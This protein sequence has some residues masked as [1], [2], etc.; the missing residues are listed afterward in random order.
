MQTN[1]EQL[2]R[3]WA[4]WAPLWEHLEDQ[5][6]GTATAAQ[7][8]GLVQEPVLVLGAGQGLVVD[9]YRRLGLRAFGLD[10]NPA[11]VQAGRLRRGLCLVQAD[12][13][14]LPFLAQSFGTVIFSSGVV[15]YGA[16]RDD[17]G[18]MLG[19]ARRVL[20]PGGRIA[21]AFYQVEPE[22]LAIYRKLGVVAGGA[23]HPERMFE[24]DD[25]VREAPARAVPKIAAWSGRSKASSFLFFARL[26]LRLPRA[27]E[28]ERRR[29]LA[30][31]RLAAAQGLT[32]E[33]LVASFPTGVPYRTPEE[34]VAL[35]TAAG[36]RAPELTGTPDCLV[37]TWVEGAAPA[38]PGT[39]ARGE[40][41][42]RARGL[43]K[44]Y[45]GAAA[46]AV[47]GIDLEVE[48]GAIFGLLGPNGAGKTTTVAML[49]GL[50][51]PDA[52]QVAFFGPGGEARPADAM[53]KRLGIVPQ[54]L[55]LHARL[56]AR[57]NLALFGGL[58]AL[59]GES[60]RQRAA[61]LLERVGLL[62][63]A[64]DRVDT[65][66]TG[67]KRRLNLAAGLLHA[68]E[69]LLLDEPT[70]G[71]DPQ[72][73]HAIHLL[74]AE[75]RRAGMTLLYTTHDMAEAAQLCDR[76]AILDRGNVLIE[77]PPAEL[78]RRLGRT[79]ADFKAA[80]LPEGM[81]DAVRAAP[82]VRFA[83]H[84]GATLT[85]GAGAEVGALEL[86]EAV[87]ALGR[88]RGLSLELRRVAEPSLESVFLDL[89]GRGL[90]DLA[91]DAA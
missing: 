83:E 3:W 2:D 1:L 76:V 40:V 82:Q 29:M 32:R 84:E 54:E 73:R 72:S 21:A 20:R 74:L 68:P 91:E 27:L 70:A 65:F 43:R 90:R 57:E 69:L 63:R 62:D 80:T 19:E 88:E 24:I 42:L 4:A 36:A 33:A 16:Q 53:R 45:R 5:H 10:R 34:A 26:G 56:T 87:R 22:L 71:V 86:V 66:S 89:T 41:A 7:L 28:R 38:A 47:R 12:A 81:L 14:A 55:A 11:M 37:V 52:G 6:F 64:D 39:R 23:Y 61:A 17:L 8:L 78:V 9:Y 85:V 67:M 44:R 30:V 50:L 15:D 75:Q 51:S 58:Y 79:T 77:G 35:L 59:G 25:A 13:R 31:L 49:A 60:L 48:R 18:T 46:E